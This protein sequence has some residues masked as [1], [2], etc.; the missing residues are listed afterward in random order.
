MPANAPRYAAHSTPNSTPTFE[1]G[2]GLGSAYQP[3]PTWNEG[4]W[5]LIRSEAVAPCVPKT[6]PRTH[7]PAIACHARARV[8][9]A[10]RPRAGPGAPAVP[11]SHNVRMH[12]IGDPV[13]GSRPRT[14]YVVAFPYL[15]SQTSSHRRAR[16]YSMTSRRLLPLPKGH[17]KPV[18]PPLVCSARRK[19][20][21]RMIGPQKVRALRCRDRRHGRA[22][23]ADRSWTSPSVN[24]E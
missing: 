20:G 16:R 23:T 2:T 4:I 8:I 17:R 7:G 18:S 15:F 6:V 12:L 10:R 1:K 3:A 21:A 19:P 22:G 14:N 9:Q 11:C 24:K 13:V 5:T